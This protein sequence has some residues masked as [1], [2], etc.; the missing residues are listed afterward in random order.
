MAYQQRQE[1]LHTGARSEARELSPVDPCYK[2][3][4]RTELSSKRMDRI[5]VDPR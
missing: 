1:G 5:L 3:E 2:I 4:G